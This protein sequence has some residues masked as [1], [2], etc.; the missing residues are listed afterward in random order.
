[1]PK[2]NAWRGDASDKWLILASVL[3]STRARPYTT[4]RS[5]ERTG[6]DPA[7]DLSAVLPVREP[8]VVLIVNE[9]VPTGAR[10]AGGD[11]I[12]EL[13]TG[14]AHWTSTANPI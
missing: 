7:Y 5:P 2:L 10:T 6:L 12:Y 8:T 9:C 14:S 11:I 4:A 1:M 13:R 3:W